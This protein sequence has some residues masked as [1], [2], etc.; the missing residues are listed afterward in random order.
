[1]LRENCLSEQRRG[2]AAPGEDRVLSPHHKSFHISTTNA[3]NL[4]SKTRIPRVDTA[5]HGVGTP[6]TLLAC[7]WLAGAHGASGRRGFASP[8][9]AEVAP[10]TGRLRSHPR[11]TNPSV[12][13]QFQQT[14]NQD[15]DPTGRYR[16]TQC[17]NSNSGSPLSIREASG[18][19]PMGVRS[20]AS[21]LTVIKY[22]TAAFF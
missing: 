12:S 6:A 11:I 4:G 1:M 13:L 2:P 3:N 15:D 5:P 7:C 14:E 9:K 10:L 18:P 22:C 19:H 20:S 21:S 16:P 17:S 8:A